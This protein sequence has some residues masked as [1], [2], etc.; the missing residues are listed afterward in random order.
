MSFVAVAVGGVVS[1]G[2]SIAG[3]AMQADAAEDAA[4]GQLQAAR[5]SNALQERIWNEQ[6]DMYT[7]ARDQQRADMDPWRTAG[8][9]ALSELGSD[10]FR[11]D[12]TAKDME[13]DP[14]YAFRMGEAQKAIERSAAAKGGLQSGGTMK[15]LARFGQ[16]YASNEYDKAFNRFNANRNTRFS[17]LSTIAGMG[18]N[19]AAGMGAGSMNAASGMAAAGGNYAGAVGSN[20]MGAANAAGA[21]GMASANSWSNSLSGIGRMGM[22]AALMPKIWG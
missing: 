22:E 3:S 21:A 18:Q 9:G 13:L 15:A 14:G 8:A 10:D 19:A 1:A 4:N 6:R 11:R 7:Q 20:T 12:F 17:R 16:D 2:A 5:E